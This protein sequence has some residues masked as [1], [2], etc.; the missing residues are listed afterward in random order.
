M[1]QAIRRRIH[2]SPATAIATLALVF[3]MTGGAYAAKHY[4]ITSTKQISPKV[5]AQLKG[6]NGKNGATG[7]AGATGPGGLAG[8]AGAKGENGAAGSAGA[9][10]TTGETGPKG[11]TGAKGEQG[12]QGIQG[13]PGANGE[14]VTG[15]TITSGGSKCGGQAGVEYT[16]KSAT[17]EVC[18]GQ[19][20]FT[21]TLPSGETETGTYGFDVHAAGV[22]YEPFSFPIPLAAPLAGSTVHFIAE[23]AAP[24]G[25]NDT[26]ECKG[27]IAEPKATAGN[28][29]MYE[30]SQPV[31]TALGPTT[32][33]KGGLVVVFFVSE[34]PAGTGEAASSGSWAV[35]AP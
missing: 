6:A 21:K 7:P 32:L 25:G 14:S 24:G 28:L 20:G 12:I 16:L 34:I 9:K 23:T 10:G 3:A 4:L 19:T 2:V 30:T 11:A 33:G 1:F 5:L 22:V 35:T 31:V 18:N 15:K 8:A 17:T 13:N 29:C 27:T 26:T